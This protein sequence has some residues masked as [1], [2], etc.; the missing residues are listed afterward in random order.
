MKLKYPA[1]IPTIVAAIATQGVMV[2]D[3]TSAHKS[4]AD[5]RAETKAAVR[6][7]DAARQ[8]DDI[9][10][11]AKPNVMSTGKMSLR[12]TRAKERAEVKDALKMGD[13]PSDDLQDVTNSK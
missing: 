5:V 8:G 1:L 10:N 4:R 2:Q 6:S 13:I 7:G 3:A 9:Q 11:I 12:E